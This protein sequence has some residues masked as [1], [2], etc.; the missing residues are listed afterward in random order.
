MPPAVHRLGKRDVDAARID[1]FGKASGGVIAL[2]AAALEPIVKQ[3]VVIETKA[4]AAGA[5][6]AQFAAACA[7]RRPSMVMYLIFL[8]PMTAPPPPRPWLRMLPSGSFTE[9]FA[10]AILYSPAGPQTTTPIF[11]PRRSLTWHQMT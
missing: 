4:G 8:E 9:M 5:V 3:P 2:F 6:G 11:L 10:A 7:K 1:V